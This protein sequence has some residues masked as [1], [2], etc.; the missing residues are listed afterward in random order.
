MSAPETDV[1]VIGGGHAGIEAATAAARL[2]ADTLLVTLDPARI[3][4]MSCNPAIG[5]I[6]KGQIVR[7]IDA[8]GGVMGLAADATGIQF[9]MLNRSKGPAVWG[10]RCQSDRHAYA[11]FTREY[12][13]RQ[14]NLRIL[15]GEAVDLRDEHGRIT[16]VVVRETGGGERTITSRTAVVTAGTFLN[17]LMHLGERSWEGGRYEEPAARGLSAALARAG[18]ELGRLK[19]GTCPRLDAATIDYDRCTRQ[20]GDEPPQAF[21]FL[22]DRLDV[23]Q[24]PCWLTATTEAVHEA[25]RRNLHRAP[26]YTGQIRSAG[27]RYC[28]SIETKIERFAEKSSH[29]VFL[30]P[31][32]RGTDWLYCNGIPT[33]LPEDVQA[34]IVAKIPG[35][36]S[37]RVLRWGY[38]IEYDFAPP[39]QLDAGL[40]SRHLGGMFLAGQVN[41]TTGYEE[42]A[43]Q[44][45][46]AGVNAVRRA[47]GQEP[48]V[49]G[50]DRSYIGVMIDDLVTKGV[51][52]PYRMFTSRAEHRLHLRAD[53]AD[54][55]LTPLAAE[56]GLIDER[57]RETFAA[58]RQA[59]ETARRVL[60]THRTADRAKSLW[61]K[62]REPGID[63]AAVMEG[64]PEAAGPL[65]ELLAAQP[66]AV[67]SLAVDARYAGYL[68]KQ[69]QAVRRLREH[70]DRRIPES[71]DYQAVSHLRE[72]ARE[73]LRSARPHTLAQALRLGGI[74]PADIAVL[75]IHLA[76]EKGRRERAG[77]A[78]PSN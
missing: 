24:V 30:E 32:G 42:A 4:E 44:G 75:G 67:E 6:G 51:R 15:A 19:T 39:T 34:E 50:R 56:L 20:D 49:L 36:E 8:M 54:R 1:I 41:G 57:R 66:A 7:E 2:G 78:K 68:Q 55:R 26:L 10:P 5:G 70:E 47:R 11:A 48:L 52:E 23:E 58:A 31:E 63:L 27:P 61:E 74:T 25:I 65:K 18:L 12:L 62:L 17:G 72:E 60:E 37:A 22:H 53:N 21:S 29:N 35:C 38:A 46:V 16:G 73:L 33:S 64:S 9:R 13:A 3:G 77:E 28:P 71:L 45:L 69:L 43:G 14:A 59:V 40:Q 76:A